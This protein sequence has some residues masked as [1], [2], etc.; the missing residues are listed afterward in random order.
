M[1]SPHTAYVDYQQR[2]SEFA[3]G[4]IVYPFMLGKPGVNGR[5]MAVWPAI[6]MVDV[7]W[8]HGSERLPVEEIQRYDAKDYLPSDVGH[9]NVP[10]GAGT[11]SVSGGPVAKAASIDLKAS[12]R[13]VAEAFVK[14]SL[15]WGA[16]GR[17]YRATKAEIISGRFCCPKCR[18]EES[19]LRK[20]NYK[21]MEGR[22]DYLLG[23][24]NC[25]F[26][27]KRCDLIGH[28]DHVVETEAV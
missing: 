5:V 13:R 24:P 16:R 28:P 17:K 21:R 26:V 11:V 6:G 25:M 19:I 4:D 20:V 3:I 8:P 7:E 27:I 10:G 2:A 14:K 23:C 22:S 9:D 12:A 15:Y 1:I 18:D